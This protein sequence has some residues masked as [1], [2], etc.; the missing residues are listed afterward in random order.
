MNQVGALNLSCSIPAVLQ[1]KLCRS[2]V[3]P[4]HWK[5][6]RGKLSLKEL[7]GRKMA[8]WI[9]AVC[10]LVFTGWFCVILV[11]QTSNRNSV[12]WR[13]QPPL[14]LLNS[15]YFCWVPISDRAN[16]GNE[17]VSSNGRFNLTELWHDQVL[18]AHD[19]WQTGTYWA[20]SLG[21]FKCG[22]LWVSRTFNSW[23]ACW[24]V[25]WQQV[26]GSERTLLLSALQ[27]ALEALSKT[28]A[29]VS[30]C[31]SWSGFN[32]LNLESLGP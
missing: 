26:H 32:A 15:E 28:W 13:G 24:Q 29:S 27:C 8:S 11:V 3:S 2:S 25:W 19:H 30:H 7:L 17:G 4:E 12:D 20:V 21:K 5:M 23:V 31:T 14:L 1:C 16:R 22:Q 9:N 10:G 6:S 18:E